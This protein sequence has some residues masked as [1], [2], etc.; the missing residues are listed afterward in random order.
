[1]NA[2]IQIVDQVMSTPV[3]TLPADMSTLEALQ[4]AER[5]GLHHLP[6]LDRG[7]VVGL[8]CTC[9]LLELDMKAPIRSAVRRRVA[10]IAARSN[11]EQAAR[12]MSEQAIGSLL[13][14]DQG[15]LVGI[16]TRED[17]IEAGV[18]AE[19]VPHFRCRCCGSV[20]HLRCDG[21]RGTLCLDCRSRAE[22]EVPGDGTGVGD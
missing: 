17:L 20:S 3:K 19:R 12:A 5:S 4:L 9:D 21:E 16:V 13:V 6:L 18:D 7:K 22:P 14:T 11:V 8:V 10:T 1:M 2:S 15:A